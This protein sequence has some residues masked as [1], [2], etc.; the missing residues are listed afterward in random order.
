MGKALLI[1]RQ[2]IQSSD[3]FPVSLEEAWEWL[4]Y[5]RKDSAKRA[6]LNAGFIE[7]QDF[8]ISVEPTTTGISAI[9]NEKVLLTIECFKMWAMMDGALDPAFW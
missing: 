7:D 9:V 8:H 3:L 1:R 6:L 5:S 4:G 2:L